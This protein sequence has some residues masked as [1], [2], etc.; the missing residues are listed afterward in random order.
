MLW[1]LVCQAKCTSLLWIFFFGKNEFYSYNWD[2][3]F[4]IWDPKLDFFKQF[5]KT[6]AL[7]DF[8]FDYLELEGGLFYDIFIKIS[9]GYNFINNSYQFTFKFVSKSCTVSILIFQSTLF[10]FS[11]NLSF[12]YRHQSPL[13]TG[14]LLHFGQFTSNNINRWSPKKGVIDLRFLIT[15]GSLM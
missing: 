2:S 12:E 14:F 9:E 6:I 13:F 1:L 15:V 11:F 5:K 10:S 8:I 3:I 4:W 7:V